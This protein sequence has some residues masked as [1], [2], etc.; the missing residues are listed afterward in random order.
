MSSPEGVA[1]DPV[2]APATPRAIVAGHAEFAFGLVSA[3]QQITGRGAQL[4]PIDARALGVADIER[5]IGD[6]M[7]DVGIRVVFTDLHAGSC[8]MA[9]RRALRLAPEAVLVAGTN[10]PML[11]DFVLADGQSAV[12][13]ATHAAE[14][15]REAVRVIGGGQ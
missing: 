5:L 10:L 11:L 3:V 8:T 9:A 12:E 14:R 2:A 1:G 15:G 4:L 6:T 13:A 7:R